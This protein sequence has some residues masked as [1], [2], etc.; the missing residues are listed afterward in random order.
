MT[1]CAC[2]GEFVDGNGWTSIHRESSCTH[3]Y[4]KDE[5][6]PPI[7][8]HRIL[9]TASREWSD[10]DIIFHALNERLME[11][12]Y[13]TVIQGDCTGGDLISKEWAQAR[14]LTG[15]RLGEAFIRLESY[16]APWDELGKSAGPIRN[17]YMVQLG[18]DECLAFPLPQSRGTIGCMKLAQAA[19]I[20]VINLGTLPD[21]VLFR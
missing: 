7:R 17:K 13:V 10:K 11:H 2:K 3:Q 14:I 18:A 6:V 4:N 12:S 8:W 9:I 20:P 5:Y 15:M 21:G 19:G 16:A 1:D